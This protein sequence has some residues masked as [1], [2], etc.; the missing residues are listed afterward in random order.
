[1]PFGPASMPLPSFKSEISNLKLLRLSPFQPPTSNLQPPARP[2]FGPAVRPRFDAIAVSEIQN[3]PIEILRTRWHFGRR[4]GACSSRQ[5]KNGHNSPHYLCVN[6]LSSRR[7][8]AAP[9]MSTESLPSRCH[10]D[11]RRICISTQPFGPASMPLPSFKSE[12]LNLKLL[13]LSPFQQL[14]TT[15]LQHSPARFSV[16]LFGPAFRP[17]SSTPLP[18]SHLFLATS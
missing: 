4:G 14:R 1:M 7:D 18:G 8:S 10:P 17:R 16:P 2:T 11:A 13:R 3:C 15:S 5:R 6:R 12:I 9:M